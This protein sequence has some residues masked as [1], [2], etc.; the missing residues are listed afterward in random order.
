MGELAAN[1][2]S[3]ASNAIRRAFDRRAQLAVEAKLVLDAWKNRP[4][5]GKQMYF[6]WAIEP[7][8]AQDS[9]RAETVAPWECEPDWTDTGK[10]VGVVE[11]TLSHRKKTRS[12]KK[13]RKKAKNKAFFRPKRQFVVESWSD[14]L[15]DATGYWK[16]RLQSDQG[17]GKPVKFEMK[18]GRLAWV[19]GEC[20]VCFAD[21]IVP[22]K[23]QWTRWW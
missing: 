17:K 3:L 13:N 21:E 8:Q 22:G 2:I 23:Y 19:V 5:T 16:Y 7:D 15:P 4:T 6:A 14:S 18:S 11:V 1:P 9:L 10:P 20:T 12:Q